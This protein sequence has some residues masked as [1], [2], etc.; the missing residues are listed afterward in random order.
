ML[1][2]ANGL[3][4]ARVADDLGVSRETGR[5]WRSR[6]AANRLEGWWTSRVRGPRGRSRTSRSKPWSP[7]PSARRR[8][9]VTISSDLVG[10]LLERPDGR[11]RLLAGPRS[12]R[13]VWWPGRPLLG[14]GVALLR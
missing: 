9:R 2:C 12:P 13:R 6:F 14:P 10:G 1:A 11:Q 3:S 5:K 8:Q 7:G 4:N